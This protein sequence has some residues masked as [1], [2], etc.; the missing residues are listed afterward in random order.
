MAVPLS[1]IIKKLGLTAATNKRGRKIIVGII[2]G[3][4]FLLSTPAM[5]LLGL[6][7]GNMDIRTGDIQDVVSERKANAE[8]I[9]AQI[10]EEMI[11]SGY[12]LKTIK[13]AQTVY[14]YILFEYGETDG[15]IQR[16]VACFRAEYTDEILSDRINAEFN[17]SITA[18]ELS[19]V[20]SDIR[21]EFEKEEETE[22]EDKR[23][24]D[25]KTNSDNGNAVRGIRRHRA[26][27]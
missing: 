22:N 21:K 3:T 26:V 23:N 6:F 25:V 5:V 11:E 8:V 20:L 2:L 16:L 1:V 24:A 17:T 10:A 14:A 15:F 7:S 13:E 12:E 4:L 27:V 9:T 18:E 19:A